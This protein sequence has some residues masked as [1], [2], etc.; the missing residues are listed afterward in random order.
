MLPPLRNYTH[1]RTSISLAPIIPLFVPFTIAGE[2]D[3]TT[4]KTIDFKPHINMFFKIKSQKL[5]LTTAPVSPKTATEVD[6][7][8]NT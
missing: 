2:H 7:L 4:H 6:S 5:K 3:T 8:K 1:Q